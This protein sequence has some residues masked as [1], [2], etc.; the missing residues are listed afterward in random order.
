MFVQLIL[1]CLRFRFQSFLF[2]AFLLAARG[3]QL[4]D[5]L[6]QLS[7]GVCFLLSQT[8]QLALLLRQQKLAFLSQ[9]LQILQIILRQNIALGDLVAHVHLVFLQLYR[10][11]CELSPLL[12]ADG[13][14]GVHAHGDGLTADR[15]FPS[16]GRF[17]LR[18]RE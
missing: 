1:Q 12:R 2:C 8:I 15:E 11:R 6:L 4:V 9:A 17:L 13:A 18:L 7:V 16:Q 10:H 3:A 14:A 5:L